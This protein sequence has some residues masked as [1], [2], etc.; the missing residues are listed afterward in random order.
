MFLID[1]RSRVPPDSIP[2]CTGCQTPIMDRFILKV[3]DKAW[4]SKCLCCVDCG[5][6]LVDKCY[7]REGAVYC[8]RDFAK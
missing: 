1:Y 3:L 7:S 4:H 8:K 2:V 5:D 6:L